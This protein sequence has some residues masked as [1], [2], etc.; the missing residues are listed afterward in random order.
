MSLKKESE[1]A[2]SALDHSGL[3]SAIST[4]NMSA[5][6]MYRCGIA[7]DRWPVCSRIRQ[8][9]MPSRAAL[10]PNRMDLADRG[11]PALEG[12]DGQP[13]ERCHYDYCQTI[14]L[15]S[16]DFLRETQV[17]TGLRGARKRYC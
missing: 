15:W 14:H 8:V 17:S 13:A 6:R 16:V 1:F 2:P 5:S 3:I 12:G 7:S 9:G 10:V 11:E 4:G